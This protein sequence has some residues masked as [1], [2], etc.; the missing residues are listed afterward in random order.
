MKQLE[1][2]APNTDIHASC[3]AYTV[4]SPWDGM[5]VSVVKH[6]RFNQQSKF[7]IRLKNAYDKIYRNSTQNM[8]SIHL[9][10]GSNHCRNVTL[11][12]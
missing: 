12:K 11:M 1:S 10:A 8:T 9:T 5:H 3:I 6:V 7:I 4:F 2:P